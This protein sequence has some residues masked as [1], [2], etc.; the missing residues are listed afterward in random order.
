[1]GEKY[2]EK[3]TEMRSLWQHSYR[4]ALYAYLLA[5]GFKRRKEILDDVYV[6]GI[7]HD[8]G[9]IVI[10]AMHPELLE[11]ITR[12]CKEKGIEG[13][14]L[15][16]FSVGLNHAEVGALIARKWN[17]P[18][19][20]V[21]A[22]HY[23]HEPTQAPA[24]SRDIVNCVYLANAICDVEREK[25]GWDQLE[26]AVLHDFGIETRE[27]FDTIQGRLAKAFEDQRARFQ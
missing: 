17:F 8:L 19:Q 16:N 11:R 10:A 1:M 2:S 6:G 5:K 18:E 14:L 24:G 12:V 21:D 13:R 15:E 22:I 9:Q 3:Y 4:A 20:L 7:L 27:Q 26:T 25:I 23:H